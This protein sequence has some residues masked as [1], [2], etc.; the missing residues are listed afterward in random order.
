MATDLGGIGMKLSRERL[1]RE[2]GTTG[3]RPESLEKVI[4]LV[5]LLNGIFRSILTICLDFTQ[6]A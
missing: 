3:F 4:R 6:D 2:S 5:G 1:L